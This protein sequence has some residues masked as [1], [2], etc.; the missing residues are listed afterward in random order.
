[1]SSVGLG[2]IVSDCFGLI[3]GVFCG[4]FWFCFWFF[5]VV[6]SLWKTLCYSAVEMCLSCTHR[7]ADI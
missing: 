4:V 2:A 1:M 7:S 6:V 3:L 5:F